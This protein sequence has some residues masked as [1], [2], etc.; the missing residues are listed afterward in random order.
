M[1]NGLHHGESAARGRSDP[2]RQAAVPGPDGPRVRVV[3]AVRV[4]AVRE[5]VALEELTG[6]YDR[7]YRTVMQVLG[8]QGISPAGPAL[9]AYFGAPSETVDVAAGFPVSGRVT[10]EGEVRLVELPAGRVAEII[11][12]GSY[13]TLAQ[14]Y[15][16]LEDWVRSEGL[17]PGEIT[18]ES[19]ETMP[20]PEADPATM[21]T[22]ICWQLAEQP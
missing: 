15:Q 8:G 6:F 17:V 10:P 20:T 19:Y 13:D 2:P 3:D 9:G 16:A 14:T 22:R 18:W 1:S 5:T 12:R 7:A 21:R 11:H 4:A